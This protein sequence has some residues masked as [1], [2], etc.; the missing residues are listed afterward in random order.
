[1]RTAIRVLSFSGQFTLDGAVFKLEE[2]MVPPHRGSLLDFVRGLVSEYAM[3]LLNNAGAMLGKS[4][5]LN[6]P[7]VPLKLGMTGF[8]YM[9]DSLGLAFGEAA[10]L[11]NQLTFDDDYVTQQRR[12]RGEKKIGGLQDGVVEAGK[13]LAQGVEGLLDVVVKPIEGA[14]KN[15][16]GG[17][18][19]GFG[20]GMAGSF[21]KPISKLGQAF[22]D[23]GSGLA[24]AVTPD[25]ASMKRRRMRPRWRQPRLLFSQVGIV[26][27]WSELDAEL[28]RQLGEH[29]MHGVEEVVPLTQQGSGR[30]VLLLYPRYLVLAE[31]KDPHTFDNSSAAAPRQHRAARDAAAGSTSGNRGRGGSSSSGSWGS[32]ATGS[33]SSTAAP[34]SLK[35]GAGSEH[36][37]FLN[38]IEES[39]QKLFSQTLKPINTVVFGVQDIESKL[40]GQQARREALPGKQ[41]ADS[42]D[43]VHS[44]AVRGKYKF[45]CVKDVHVFE[46]G[47]IKLEDH[48][49]NIKELSLAAAGLSQAA[50][51]ALVSGFRSA[52]SHHGGVANW[53]ELQTVLRQ[54]RWRQQDALQLAA[55]G[56][57]GQ[58]QGAGQRTLEVFEVERRVFATGEW[59]TPYL[60]TDV[61]MA[62]RWLDSSGYHHPHLSRRLKREQC[63]D[64]RAPPVELDGNLF[65]PTTEW[66]VD[67][68]PGTDEGGWKYGIAWNSSTWDAK[69]SLFNGVRRRRW[70]RVYA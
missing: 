45:R 57:D 38:A 61:E 33:T 34:T 15:G 63:A 25:T 8:S 59:R 43:D 18:F 22:S 53:D 66:T 62:W 39:A 70:T 52:I 31:I 1:M 44:P 17:F 21:V 35:A 24:A 2:R 27:P 64:R 37:D 58:R 30:L 3:N 65:K 26:R 55:R 32:A 41:G 54:E 69:P 23:V 67:R 4:S 36:V 9:S 49:G 29:L 40:S 6:L 46:E 7:R 28:L 51:N 12:L 60:P 14:Q 5:V 48:E 68:G 42:D 20:K 13:S 16:V 56:G 47:L 50:F 19:A 11:L 10:S